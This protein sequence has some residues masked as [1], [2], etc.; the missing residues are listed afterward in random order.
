MV[1]HANVPMIVYTARNTLRLETVIKMLV[2]NDI[3]KIVGFMEEAK[4]VTSSTG[5]RPQ[6]NADMKETLVTELSPACW[7][8]HLKDKKIFNKSFQICTR[9]FNLITYNNI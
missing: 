5:R 4:T 7:C 8:F 2:N 3:E 9:M 1:L 6:V